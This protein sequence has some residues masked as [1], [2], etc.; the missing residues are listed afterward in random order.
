MN[1]RDHK[2]R[3]RAIKQEVRREGGIVRGWLLVLRW[4]FPREIIAV[5]VVGAGEVFDASPVT[6][7][8]QIAARVN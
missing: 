6:H 2:K 7:A 3:L 1:L 8:Q 5:V 4:L